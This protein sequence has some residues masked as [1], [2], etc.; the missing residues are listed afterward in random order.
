ME[1]W[2]ITTIAALLL[3]LLGFGI[4]QQNQPPQALPTPGMTPAATPLPSPF[5][6]KTLP[7]WNFKTWN[8]KPVPLAS[9]GGKPAFI[10]IFRTGCSHCQ[11]AAPFLA[12]LEKR[13]RP[14]GLKMVSIQSPGDYK[15]SLNPENSWA[16]VKTWLAERKI[17]SPV[18]FDEG[19]KYFQGTVKKQILGGDD[20]QL[21]YP[22]MLFTDKTGKVDFG[23]TGFD[24]AKAI[25][26]GVEM[27]R[28]FPTS[29]DAAKNAADLAKWLGQNLPGLQLDA[30][31]EKALGDD[32]ATRLK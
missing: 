19:S 2:K 28:R 17:E 24:M 11:D 30:P 7:P 31:M 27:E 1:K 15:D 9:L 23:Q 8:S 25:T 5:L 18:A 16:E 6:G 12:A 4:F 29:S 21:L 22:T 13:Y 32:I 26:L 10:E 20:K 14:R 3:G